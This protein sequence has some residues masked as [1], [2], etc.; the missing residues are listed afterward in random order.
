MDHIIKNLTE[1]IRETSYE[2][3]RYL[4]Q[5]HLE[6]IYENSLRN[7]LRKKGI[8]TEQQIPLKVYDEDGSL[9]GDF[10]ADLLIEN[11]II[12]ELKACK[13]LA[14]EHTAQ[15]LGYLRAS[16]LKHGI[17][18]NFGSH[19]LELICAFCGQISFFLRLISLG[20][21]RHK[22][23]RKKIQKQALLSVIAKDT[24]I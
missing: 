7:R 15:I 14:P 13:Y 23:H 11:T 1:I 12:I 5:G 6:K 19:K 17:L 21:K 10:K 24:V 18:V 3:H 22:I 20:H 4:S 9:L 2:L 16:R 8:L